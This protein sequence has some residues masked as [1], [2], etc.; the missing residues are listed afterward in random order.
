[1]CVIHSFFFLNEEP[2]TVPSVSL[3][4]GWG[5]HLLVCYQCWKQI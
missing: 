4:T 1:M 3:L 5:Y 2:L